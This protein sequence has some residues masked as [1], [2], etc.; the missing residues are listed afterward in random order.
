MSQV[1][2]LTAEI[3]GEFEGLLRT[4]AVDVDALA[5][6]LTNMQISDLAKSA[7]LD[8]PEEVTTWWRWRNGTRPGQALE[9]LPGRGMIS[10][11]HALASYAQ[12]INPDLG[13][14]GDP[15]RALRP[16]NEKAIILVQCSGG[17]HTAAPVFSLYDWTSP[18]RCVLPS[19]GE[20]VLT[21]MKY[22]NDGVYSADP[23]AGWSEHQRYP[24]EVLEVGLV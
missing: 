7:G 10:L 21:W 8:L 20:L 4:K 17:R 6:G 12:N 3:L 22:I 15:P 16:V 5:P 14:F 19:F 9:M 24:D 23:V 1:Q 11:E 2:L 18:P 13:Y